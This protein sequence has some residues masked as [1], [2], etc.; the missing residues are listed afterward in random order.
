MGL[1]ISTEAMTSTSHAMVFD[2][3]SH[4]RNLAQGKKGFDAEQIPGAQHASLD[5]H[6][7]AAPGAG[8]RHPLPEREVLTDQFQRWGINPETSLVFLIKCYLGSRWYNIQYGN[9][10]F[11]EPS[12]RTSR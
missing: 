11:W 5:Q 7:A 12:K 10:A 2:C 6:L 8:G 4:L 9:S 1:L 3:G